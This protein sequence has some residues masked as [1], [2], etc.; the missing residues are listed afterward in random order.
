MNL[1]A[2]KLRVRLAI[3][4]GR[5]GVYVPSSFGVGIIQTCKIARKHSSTKT[6]AGSCCF[7]ELLYSAGG[8]LAGDSRFSRK[9]HT[10]SNAAEA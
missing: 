3:F 6:K 10:P 9:S 1:G 4:L 5:A 8:S 7:G 2:P